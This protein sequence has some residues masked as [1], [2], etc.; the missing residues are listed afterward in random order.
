MHLHRLKLIN[1]R[2]HANT[3][4]VF[5][6]GITAIIGPNGSGKTTLLEAI[7]WGLYGAQA[8]R[9]NRDSI[10]WN[11]APVR[12][13]VKVEVDFALGA[14]EY[15]ISR[16][17]YQAELFID[18]ARTPA[19]NGHQEVTSRVTRLLGMNLEEFFNTYFTGQ[20]ELAVMAALT[21]AERAKFLSRILG[22]ERL[23][24]VQDRLG[25]DRSLLRGELAAT[26]KSLPDET[27][28]KRE[29]AEALDNVQLA[30]QRREELRRLN[31]VARKELENVGPE[32]SR[33][34]EVREK[35]LASE[36]DLKVGQQIVEDGR[37]E[38]MR[39][40]RELAEAIRARDELNSL[41]EVLGSVPELQREVEALEC[42][43]QRAGRRRTLAGTIEEVNTQLQRLE[44]R[45]EAVSGATEALEKARKMVRVADHTLA[46]VQ[47]REQQLRTAWVRDRQDADTKLAAFRD[48]YGELAKHR[49]KLG[50]LGPDG[51][52]PTC[53]RVLG[54]EFD[55]V[56]ESLDGQLEEVE[57]SG[58]FF[59]QRVD[60]LVRESDELVQASELKNRA[61]ASAESARQDVAAREAQFREVKQLAGELKRQR[62]HRKELETRL[63]ALPDKYDAK[64]HDE[65]RKRL[66]ELEPVIERATRF[67]VIAEQANKLIAETARVEQE[68]SD[69]E[70][71]V[72]QLSEQIKSLDFSQ[73]R[74][75]KSRAACEEVQAKIQDSELKIATVD[76]DLRALQVGIDGV[77]QK[78]QE[79]TKQEARLSILKGDLRT[80]EVLDSAISDLRTE[81]N[82]RMRPEISEIAS[83]FLAE[84]TDGR[85]H[86]LELDES[87]R[88]RIVEDGI[89]KAVIS[90]G[91]EDISNLVLRLAISQMVAER[92]GHPL[93]LLVL[94]E[95]FGSLDESKRE[96]VV[97]LLRRLGD[98]FPQVVLISHIESVREGVDRVLRVRFDESTG[99]S[100]ITEGTGTDGNKDLAA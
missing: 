27:S 65:L 53:S 2:Q 68:V 64:R 32:W 21:P 8:A 84:L 22:Y 49:K 82:A 100:V 72:D 40:D 30:R 89:S 81:L 24:Q 48:Q 38:F 6:S 50:E 7:A 12:A 19:A 95:I 66:R 3:E 77:R 74:F 71:R 85:Y 97:N 60:Q 87:Y 36:S 10:R 44:E 80:N 1:F 58:R 70:E 33:L 59:K 67:R 76:G 94:D 63:T 98:R 5:G 14:H 54:K 51:V 61:L 96:S 17:L 62:N 42:E 55:R 25:S 35:L 28:L 79:R 4:I 37:R 39:L 86:E 83:G 78:I 29:L 20:K 31:E 93:S 92:A 16:G 91:E 52:C 47:Q 43:S 73:E 88:I 45:R 34:V 11:R 69:S 18:R 75:D 13:P 23:K 41:E 99:T 15:R 56:I 57:S 9:G 26:E 46:E 90:G